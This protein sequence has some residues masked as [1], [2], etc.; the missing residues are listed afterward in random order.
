L[1]SKIS[2]A[3]RAFELNPFRILRL[4]VTATTS[5]AVNRAENALTLARIGLSLDEPDAMPWLTAPG[6]YELQQAAQTIEEPLARLKRQMLWFDRVRDPNAALLFEALREPRGPAMQEYLGGTVE[7]PHVD[8]P[9]Q[10]DDAKLIVAE[11]VAELPVFEGP[12]CG[13]CNLYGGAGDVK[14]RKC[15]KPYEVI[16]VGPGP[17]AGATVAGVPA[18]SDAAKGRDIQ[19]DLEIGFWDALLGSTQTIQVA[20]RQPCLACQGKGTRGAES[21]TCPACMGDSKRKQTCMRCGGEGSIGAPCTACR[22]TGVQ[23]VEHPVTIETPPG[24]QP[25]MQLRRRGFGL[26]SIAGGPAGDL[27]AAVKLTPHRYFQRVGDRIVTQVPMSIMEAAR[28]D[29]LEV[30]TIQGIERVAMPKE[31]RNGQAFRLPGLGVAH[32]KAGLRGDHFFK[33][34][35]VTVEAALTQQRKEILD[36]RQEVAQH[37]PALA[38]LYAASASAPSRPE[39]ATVRADLALVARRLN[40]ANLRILQAAVLMDGAMGGAATRDLEGR[41][42]GRDLWKR[43]EGLSMVPDA[44]MVVTGGSASG[45]EAAVAKADWTRALQNWMQLLA[46]PWFH[47][48]VE[49]CIADLQDDFASPDDVETIEE[50]VR[51]HLL[52]LSAQQARFLVLEGRYGMAGSMLSATA[53][54]GVELR[55][56]TPALRPLRNVFQA[57]L[58]ELEALLEQ[59]A[60]GILQSLDMYFRRLELIK[61]RWIELDAQGI[62]GLRDMIDEAVE[63]GYLRLR[64]LEKPD[65]SVDPLLQRAAGIITAQSLR[66][67]L[68]AFQTELAESRKRICYYCQTE[69]PDYE[70]SVVLKGKKVTN[71]ERFGNTTRTTYAIRHA[72]VLRCGRCARLH[73]FVRRTGHALWLAMAPGVVILCIWFLSVVGS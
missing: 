46:H 8:T 42:I 39:A 1:S 53:E 60:P 33:V 52:D 14:C 24:V 9:A 7:L 13:A 21:M 40:Q 43:L 28:G 50:S 36:I 2:P 18:A 16:D 10:R 61:K 3:L 72:W 58:S 12:Y 54:S 55:V 4:D 23:E 64:R 66:E 35:V 47:A 15:G 11:P 29:D 20:Y 27:I 32:W 19:I 65:T 70:K 31:I 62:V 73:D 57:E 59:P 26:N 5:D 49:A 63:K 45:D 71:V 48:Y 44:H 68:T 22:K 34:L 56:L 30:L 41:K 6:D 25:G 69:L 17:E 67:R 37:A 51:M 38:K